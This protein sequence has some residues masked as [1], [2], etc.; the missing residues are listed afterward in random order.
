MFPEEIDKY[1]GCVPPTLENVKKGLNICPALCDFKECTLKCDEPKLNEKYLVGKKYRNLQNNEIDYNTFNDELAR[2]EINQVKSKVKDLYRFKHV[3]LYDELITEIKKSFLD[4]QAGLFDSYFL[5]EALEEMMPK[6]ENDFNNFKDTVFDKYNRHGYLIQRDKYYLF[7]PFDE[8]NNVPM[9]YR[10]NVNISQSNQVSLKNYVKQKFGDIKSSLPVVEETIQKKKDEGYDFESTLDY[11]D[12]REENYIVGI[13][14]KNF[15]KLASNELD[16]FKI[17]APIG[18]TKD[19]KRGTGI[20]TLKGAV[21]ATSKD[22]NYLMNLI[23]KLPD[24][25]SDEIKSINKLIREDICNELRNKLLYLEKYSTKKDNNKITYVMIPINHPT[26]Q[27]PFNLEDRINYNI[28]NINKI[29][30]REIDVKVKKIKGGEFLN[31][32]SDDLISYQL[33][34]KNEK[35]MDQNN[36]IKKKLEKI[37]CKLDGKEWLLHLI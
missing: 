36:E 37:G 32:K 22:K 31:R 30:D 19:K 4:H 20:P 33:T 18:K 17:R 14:D 21:C 13:I 27:F 2:F 29:A 5:D 7:Q 9:Y 6:T 3:Y 26:L 35:F 10:E 16:L 8:N 25:T 1:K 28:K 15:N 12:S 24:I 34:F 23:K 11:Y